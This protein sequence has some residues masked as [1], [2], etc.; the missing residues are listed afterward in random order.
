MLIYQMIPNYNL[1]IVNT[2][3]S[4][5][6]SVVMPARLWRKITQR[7]TFADSINLICE[8]DVL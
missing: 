6:Y 5:R 3:V 8:K 7:R 2:V 4:W 1:D